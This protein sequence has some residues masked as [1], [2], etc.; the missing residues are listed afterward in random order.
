MIK[1][2]IYF[3]CVLTLFANSYKFDEIKYIKAVD[4]EFINSGRIDINGTKI[5]I[6]YKDRKIIKD[7]ENIQIVT[8]DEKVTNLKDN[9]KR[10]TNIMIDTMVKLGNYNLLMNENSFEKEFDKNLVNVSFK[11]DVANLIKKA[12][13]KIKD[14]KV[15]EFEMIMPNEDRLK[16]VKK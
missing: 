15:I 6:S 12:I 10:Y 7:G 3:L 8:K 11:G 1:I 9:A 16:I 5:I 14:K 4:N 2:T 13:V